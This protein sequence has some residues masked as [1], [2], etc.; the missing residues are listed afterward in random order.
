MSARSSLED[1]AS[2][3]TVSEAEPS[4]PSPRPLAAATVR[5]LRGT[6]DHPA[7]VLG[8]NANA[9]GSVRALARHGIDVIAVGATPNGSGGLDTRMTTRTR[10]ARIVE[11][12]RDQW[13]DA[14][15]DLLL[16][17]AQHW[18][19]KGVIIPSGDAEVEMLMASR[20]RLG[21]AF[22]IVLPDNALVEALS[23]KITFERI[24]RE[25]GVPTPLSY[26]GI[27]PENLDRETSA[28]R[29]PCIIKPSR[30]D[31]VW[32]DRFGVSKVLQC[33]NR[34]SLRKAFR[35]AFATHPMLIVQEVIPG[36]D[37]QIVF[38]HIYVGRDGQELALWTGQKIRQHPIHF[39]SA[40]FAAVR[41]YPEVAD[42][43]RRILRAAGKFVGYASIEYKID[44]RD[45]AFRAIEAAVGRTCYHHGLG[46]AADVNIPAIWYRDALGREVRPEAPSHDGGMWID[47]F[48]DVA[49]AMDYHRAGELTVGEWM[50]SLRGER[51]YAHLMWRD[52][53]PG[54]YLGARLAAGVVK[55]IGRRIASAL[56][57]RS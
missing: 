45:G 22:E 48:R 49:A 33:G 16:A 32:D 3:L 35:S 10:F 42:Q 37:D 8:F 7:I 25:A 9:L 41:W 55:V 6:G 17:C 40:T 31:K 2:V 44:P 20:D 11:I 28:L 12:P 36:K 39:G 1:G 46:L 26:I 21:D 19:G 30:R 4:K 51:T 24:A 13:P 43:T 29:F 5:E 23:D 57:V 52:P 56:G 15:P 38:A 50:R 34:E 54:I 47:E 14:V 53:L 18:R 27:T